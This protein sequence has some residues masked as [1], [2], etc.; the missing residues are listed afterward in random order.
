MTKTG[1]YEGE[2]LT[3]DLGAAGK[4]TR[5]L[6]RPTYVRGEYYAEQVSP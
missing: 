3:R 1:L 6:G 4:W 5:Y 2:R